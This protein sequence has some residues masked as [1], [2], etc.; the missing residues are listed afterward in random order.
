MKY[1]DRNHGQ[2][3]EMLRDIAYIAAIIG[4]VVIMMLAFGR[5]SQAETQFRL[6]ATLGSYHPGHAN[7]Y[8]QFNPGLNASVTFRADKVFQYG[9]QAGA[10]SNSYGNRTIYGLGFADT[11]LFDIGQ[12]E[13]RGGGFAGMF[14]YAEFAP[15]AA[16]HG[17]P[18]MGDF[19]LVIG[20]HVKAR[21]NNG[22]DL[23]VGF[24]PLYTSKTSGVFTLS[25]SIPIGGN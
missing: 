19:V 7:E 18:T 6:G 8:E 4:L 5:P 16:A 23:N 15:K 22:V 24:I 17:W 14:E 20:P 21:F 11:R 2:I 3:R 9:F 25:V 13:I 12:I 10:Y 1:R